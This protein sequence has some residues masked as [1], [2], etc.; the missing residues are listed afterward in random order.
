MNF[1]RF[2]FVHRGIFLGFLKT[3]CHCFLSIDCVS[4]DLDVLIALMVCLVA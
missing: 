4:M 3:D 1:L 2:D